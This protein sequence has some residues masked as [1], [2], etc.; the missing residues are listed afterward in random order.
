MPRKVKQLKQELDA[1][2][3]QGDRREEVKLCGELA[4][5]L[6]SKQEFDEGWSFH[7]RWQRCK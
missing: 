6:Y 7:E 1:A 5:A 4:D 3:R 2:V